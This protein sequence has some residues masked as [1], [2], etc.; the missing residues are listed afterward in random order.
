MYVTRAL[1]YIETCNLCAVSNYQYVY[2]F[3]LTGKVEKHDAKQ[4]GSIH[5]SQILLLNNSQIMQ[6]PIWEGYL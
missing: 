4:A 5:D 2:T 1:Y 6:K 3:L